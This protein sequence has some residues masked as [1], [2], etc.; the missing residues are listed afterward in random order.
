MIPHRRAVASDSDPARPSRHPHRA[1][2]LRR[3]R[4]RRTV[5]APVRPRRAGLPTLHLAGTLGALSLTVR[6]L[7]VRKAAR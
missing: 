1:R 4:C 6:V 2:T 5:A 7:L 3:P